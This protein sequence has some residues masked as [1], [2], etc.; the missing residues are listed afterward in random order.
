MGED[1][2]ADQNGELIAQGLESGEPGGARV[3]FRAREI[4]EEF[5]DIGPG[6]TGEKEGCVGEGR[7]GEGMIEGICPLVAKEEEG[8]EITSRCAGGRG[9]REEADEFAGFRG[10]EELAG[11]D[12]AQAGLGGKGDGGEHAV[13]EGDID[14]GGVIEDTKVW[15]GRE[16]MTGED[17]GGARGNEI[18]IKRAMSRELVEPK[19]KVGAIGVA[20]VFGHG[21]A[22]FPRGIAEAI[23]QEDGFARLGEAAGG[24]ESGV[25]G[26]KDDDVEGLIEDRSEAGLS[27]HQKRLSN[28][29][30]ITVVIQEVWRYDIAG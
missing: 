30:N 24:C 27:G 26:T 6:G 21:A 8:D 22:G 4:N 28:E 9:I 14:G 18:V 15:E 1:G 25:T 2:T 29:V 11:D 23:D 3:G 7:A 20:D 10:V 16:F 17:F 5:A 12:A 13:M 19:L